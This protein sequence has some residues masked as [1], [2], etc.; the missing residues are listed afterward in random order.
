VAYSTILPPG[1]ESQL[2]FYVGKVVSFPMDKPDQIGVSHWTSQYRTGES[3]LEKTLWRPWRQNN[4][5][6]E[7]DKTAVIVVFDMSSNTRF[8]PTHAC[9]VIHDYEINEMHLTPK[10]SAQQLQY[11]KHQ[12][13]PRDSD[14]DS[15]DDEMD[16]PEE[17]QEEAEEK[18][19]EKQKKKKPAAPPAK[20]KKKGKGKQKKKKKAVINAE[21]DNAARKRKSGL[22]NAK[23]SKRAKPR[24]RSHNAGTE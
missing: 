1:N 8:I 7:I 18:K 22:S 12:R 21:E 11:R 6:S 16:E 3:I 14:Y 15:L 9:K 17:K 2:S 24:N 5:Y 20:G 10:L 4:K 13:P 19:Q 23:G